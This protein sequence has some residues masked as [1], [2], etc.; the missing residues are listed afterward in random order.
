MR[1]GARSSALLHAY[2]LCKF[3]CT[4]GGKSKRKVDERWH[5]CLF[6]T[7]VAAAAD[8]LQESAALTF[9]AHTLL[10]LAAPS[11]AVAMPLGDTASSAVRCGFAF[12]AVLP[13]L[14]PRS[15]R[16]PLREDSNHSPPLVSPTQRAL[17]DSASAFESRLL[18][19]Y[20]GWGGLRPPSGAGEDLFN[21]PLTITV[22]ST[23][24]LLPC[25]AARRPGYPALCRAV[26]PPPGR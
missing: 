6:P 21:A 19:L 11:G 17:A 1:E 10:A 14:G 26:Q 2:A 13:A 18:S 25:R 5:P 3:R 24:L 8:L 15:R 16:V 20:H 22:R 23:G 7:A 4:I 12:S 9:H